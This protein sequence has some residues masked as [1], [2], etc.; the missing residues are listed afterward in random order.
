MP[1]WDQLW[2]DFTQEELRLS[3]VSGTSS[4]SHKS[5]AEQENVALAG[6]GKAKKGSSKGSN[7]QGEK[8]KKDLSKVKCYGCHEFGHYVSDCPQ[9]KKGKKQTTAS[10]SAD[11]LSSRMEDEFALIACMVSS[12]SQGVWYIDNGAS[13]HMTRVR[14]YFSSCKEKD[15]KIQISMGNMSK[16]NPVGKGT[17]LS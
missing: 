4:K 14:E 3:L 16:L 7:P 17:V 12:T 6:K 15:I 2:S 9:R 10:A 8:K 13:F 5:E 1:S 11:E